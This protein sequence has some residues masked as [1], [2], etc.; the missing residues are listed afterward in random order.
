MKNE[1]V[2]AKTVREVFLKKNISFLFKF[3]ICMSSYFAWMSSFTKLIFH[4]SL[5]TIL[6]YFKLSASR[7]DRLSIFDLFT[8]SIIAESTSK[9]IW[10]LFPTAIHHDYS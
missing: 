4:L 8:S 2:R 6:Q 7:G 1:L 10:F 5:Q 9:S 3:S